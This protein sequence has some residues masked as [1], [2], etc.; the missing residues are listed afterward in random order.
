MSSKIDSCLRDTQGLLA[1]P[2]VGQTV[3]QFHVTLDT[4]TKM[5]CNEVIV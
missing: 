4:Y 3:T 2:F 5:Y 1:C